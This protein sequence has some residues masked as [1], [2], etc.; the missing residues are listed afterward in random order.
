[1]AIRIVIDGYNL[2]RNYSPLARLEQQDFSRGREMLLHWLAAYRQEHP[3]AML[4]VFDGALGGGFREE[5]DL[6]KGIQVTY[7]PRGET[8]DDIIK[9]LMAFRATNT[10]VVTSDRD[11]AQFCRS[12][13]AG[14]I[15][16]REFA[17]RIQK[18]LEE[19]PR[20]DVE[21]EPWQGSGP[22]KKKGLSHRPSKKKKREMKYWGRI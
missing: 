15:G 3:G 21:E 13:G 11:L 20:T 14:T 19:R 9:R 22:R 5:H 7:S 2:I 16:A 4:V 6:F 8:A 18:R 12:Q 17:D 1:M 10:L